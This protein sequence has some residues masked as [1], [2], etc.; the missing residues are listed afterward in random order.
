L[1]IT[2]GG[3][4]LMESNTAGDCLAKTGRGNRSFLACLADEWQQ[5]VDQGLGDRDLTVVTL[6]LQRQGGSP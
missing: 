1:M 2:T 4:W 3:Y 5:V 6:A